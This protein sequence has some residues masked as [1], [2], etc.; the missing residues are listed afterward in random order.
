MEKGKVVSKTEEIAAHF[1]NYFNDI[2][3]GLKIK[4]WCISDTLPDDTLANAIRKHENH[5][6]IIKS[7][8][9]VE[10]AQ[11]F[12]FSFASSDDISKIINSMDSTKKTSGAIPIKI[13][14]LVNKKIFKDL[15][16]CINE[17]IKQSKFSNELKIADIMPIFKKEDPLEKTNYR[18][19]S[20]LPTV[21]KIFEIILFNQ[22]QRFSNKYLTPL[23]CG[24]RKVCSTQ[25]V[26]I[27]LLQ[28]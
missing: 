7:K 11:L 1:N 9:S 2:T 25:Y 24:F 20:I 15:A 5:P 22:L 17:C 26:L 10:T 21:S 28:K 8:S 14:K 13:V 6:S 18:P 23:L 4:K 12:H 19:I 27:N 3:E 16:N